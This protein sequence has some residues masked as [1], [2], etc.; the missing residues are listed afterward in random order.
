M[1]SRRCPHTVTVRLQSD[2]P[3]MT[4]NFS[5]S[6]L[7][8]LLLKLFSGGLQNFPKKCH[9]LILCLLN[10]R[11]TF[12]RTASLS[13][14]HEC[15]RLRPVKHFYSIL[16]PNK[17]SDNSETAA[18]CKSKFSMSALLTAASILFHTLSLLHVILRHSVSFTAFVCLWCFCLSR[19]MFL[20]IATFY[21]CTYMNSTPHTKYICFNK[22]YPILLYP[23]DA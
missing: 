17:I 4:A 9:I 20:S 22:F 3:H 11:K 2:I 15:L 5:T 21:A 6:L 18:V 1:S 8:G 13:L 10:I 23:F 12:S 14:T 16:K 7:I 19:H